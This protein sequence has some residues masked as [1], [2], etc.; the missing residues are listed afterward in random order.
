[1]SWLDNLTEEFLI[2]TGDGLTHRPL[3]IPTSKDIE[4]NTVEFEFINKDGALV[5]RDSKKADR[6]NLEFY[7]VGEFHL[8]EAKRFEDS[9]VDKRP[10]TIAHPYHGDLLVQVPSLK[11]DDSQYNVTKYSGLFIVTISETNPQFTSNPQDEINELGETTLG[12]LNDAFDEELS[13]SDIN[14][15]SQRN[16]R[17]YENGLKKVTDALQAEE[18]YN[19]FNQANAAVTNATQGPLEAMRATQNLITYPSKFTASVKDRFELLTDQFNTLRQVVSVT[20][21]RSTKKMYE[22][23]GGSIMTAFVLSAST[24]QS[25]DYKKNKDVFTIIDKMIELFEFYLDDLDEIQTENGGAPESYIP[26]ATALINL[27]RLVNFTL[28]NLR[29]I[30]LG[31]KMER[32]IITDK[33]TNILELTHKFYGMDDSDANLDELILNNNFGL[34]DFLQIKKGTEIIYYI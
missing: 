31:S 1:M 15:L 19:F 5:R 2:T 33:D 11:R 22:H 34:N 10:L 4:F 32:V 28:V 12:N 25:L 27:S 17:A 24:P 20:S 26:D 6:Y 23:N 8:Q 3:W 13:P 29:N 7:F 30:A 18:F 21:D 9:L 16:K 14:N